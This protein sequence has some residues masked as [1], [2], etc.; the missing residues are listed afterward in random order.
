MPTTTRAAFIATAAASGLV[1]KTDLDEALEAVR[2]GLAAGGKAPA[3]L[4]A[5]ML[6]ARLV[7][8]GKLN[9]WQAEQ[10]LA[11]RTKFTLGPY[12]VIDSI[13]QGGMGQVFKAE[14]SFMRR[15]VAI[16]VLPRHKATPE[17]I[18]NFM[19]EIQAQAQLDHENLVRAYDA[20]CDGSVHYLVTEYVP[21][22]D[23]R[24]LIRRQRKLSMRAAA[25]IVSQAALGL[26]HA[27]SRGLIH[28]DVKPGNVLVTPE[29]RTKVSDLGLAGYF[30]QDAEEEAAGEA[31][32]VGTAD[33]LSPEQIL[34]PDKLTPACDIY[35]LGCTLYYAVTGKVPFPG[36]TA[37]EKARAHCKQQPIDPRRLNPELEDE[38]VDVVAAMMAKDPAERIPRADEVVARLARWAGPPG[39]LAAKEAGAWVQATTSGPHL[40]ASP[41]EAGQVDLGETRPMSEEDAEPVDPLEEASDISHGSQNSQISQL[42]QVSQ[43]TFPLTAATEETM[44]T[45]VP[46]RMEPAGVELSPAVLVLIAIGLGAAIVALGAVF[47]LM[48]V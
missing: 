42:S 18:A 39:E 33:Y 8:S 13:G 40:F 37:Q 25:S 5:E 14:H 34:T 23:L 20:G 35:A 32:I 24:R 45:F 46:S 3:D 26:S 12:R 1:S 28:R 22:T 19:K 44:P 48:L 38:F 6:A 15:E 43:G 31:K 36:G 21:G 16:K 11:G 41:H 2:A 30:T 9:I 27:H 47:I 4:T 10:L 7:E 17:S 29:G